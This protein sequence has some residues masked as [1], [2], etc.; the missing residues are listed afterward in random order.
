MQ[1]Q[2]A[3]AAEPGGDGAGSG[4]SVG[5]GGVHVEGSDDELA[6][7]NPSEFDW[8]GAAPPPLPTEPALELAAAGPAVE[9]AG[10][11]DVGGGRGRLGTRR[12]SRSVSRSVSRRREPGGREKK[13]SK[14]HKKGCVVGV[15]AVRA[16][17]K[18]RRPPLA[19][20]GVTT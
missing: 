20:G 15:A 3:L 13:H 12:A 4:G 6:G 19:A 17:V 16:L 9:A 8:D 2:P 10:A 14:K 7:Y 1:Q 5:G 18:A 11:G